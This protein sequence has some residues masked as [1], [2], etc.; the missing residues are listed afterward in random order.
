MYLLKISD[1]SLSSQNKLLSKSKV[2]NEL[3]TSGLLMTSITIS[4]Y[5][6][7]IYIYTSFKMARL[8]LQRAERTPFPASLVSL[9]LSVSSDKD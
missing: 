4:S 1:F 7:T 2:E 8:T 9:G 3:S 5:E 6:T